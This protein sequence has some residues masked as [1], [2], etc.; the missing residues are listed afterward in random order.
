MK[1]FENEIGYIPFNGMII[2]SVPDS[3]YPDESVQILKEEVWK[4]TVEER[5]KQSINGELKVAAIGEGVTFVGV[6]D[7]IIVASHVRLQTLYKTFGEDKFPKM[8]WTIRESDILV[9]VV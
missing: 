3:V 4:N 8:F 2:L 7:T 6:G 9:K 1:E 5:A